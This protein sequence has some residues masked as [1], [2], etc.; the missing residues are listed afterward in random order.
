M[1]KEA[2]EEA[3]KRQLASRNVGYLL[4]AG[5]SYLAGGGY[6]LAAGLWDLVKPVLPEAECNDIARK[7][8]EGAWGIEHALDLLDDGGVVE[9]PH[10]VSVTNAIAK[11]FLGIA[12]SLES[13]VEFVTRIVSRRNGFPNPVFSLNYDPLVE[14]AAEMAGVKLVD[15]FWGAEKAFFDGNVFSRLAYAKQAGGRGAVARPIQDTFHLIKLHGSVGWFDYEDIGLRRCSYSCDCPDH[16]RHLMVPPQYRK[17]SDVTSQPYSALWSV[18]RMRLAHGPELL[19]RLAVIGYGMKD[20]HVNDVLANALGRD[21]F[22][23]LVFSRSLDDEA[24]GRW[25]AYRNVIIV[26]QDRCSLIGDVVEGH[27]SLWDFQVICNEV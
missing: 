7:L 11:V 21:D 1:N 23:L 10:R 22:T 6:P 19:N 4:G 2:V 20:E 16:A 12:P 18:F 13:H 25:S 24:F 15:G 27:P 8:D 14:R 17:A 5:S 9:S 26:T 3:V